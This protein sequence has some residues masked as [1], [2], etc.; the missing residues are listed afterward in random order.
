MK[1]SI[2]DAKLTVSALRVFNIL[3]N[4][5]HRN[6]YNVTP[7][8][9]SPV[10]VKDIVLNVMSFAKLMF[11]S[12]FGGRADLT[13]KILFYLS[14]DTKTAAEKSFL[15]LVAKDSCVYLYDRK[16][17]RS[18]GEDFV[19]QDVLAPMRL[20]LLYKVVSVSVGLAREKRRPFLEKLLIFTKF[21]SIVGYLISITRFFEKCRPVA[22]VNFFSGSYMGGVVNIASLQNGVKTFNYTWGSN[23]KSNEQRYAVIGS[24]LLLKSRSDIV[25]YLGRTD[26]DKIFVKVVGNLGV[27]RFLSRRVHHESDLLIVDTCFSK[28]FGLNE[29][30]YLYLTVIEKLSKRNKDIAR[31]LIKMH[32]ASERADLLEE[33]LRKRLP[34]R[35]ELS[36]KGEGDLEDMFLTSKC[37]VNICS[38]VIYNLKFSDLM[39]VNLFPYYLKTF[40]RVES[41]VGYEQFCVTGKND[42]HDLDD[43]E[44]I[45]FDDASQMVGF[46]GDADFGASAAA[47]LVDAVG[48]FYPGSSGVGLS[49]Q[50]AAG[51]R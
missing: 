11:F 41:L 24:G 14:S 27:K 46:G 26:L 1:A 20:K 4:S 19:I 22:M 21:L 40:S 48:E 28:N 8:L 32:P 12:Q 25:P 5:S 9:K 15:D 44:L 7:A 33:F 43:L 42:V 13:N 36:I 35:Y 45:D 18:S 16:G 37:I 50:V 6:P 29:K 39:V 3:A 17:S 51:A 49:G 47:N 23:V 10:R 31:V 2:V 38:T 30:S 34:A